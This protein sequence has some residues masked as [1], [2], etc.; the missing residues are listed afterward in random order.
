M[1]SRFTN[2]LTIGPDYSEKEIKEIQLYKTVASLVE[3]DPIFVHFEVGASIAANGNVGLIGTQITYFI[4]DINKLNQTI[5]NKYVWEVSLLDVSI[6]S[7]PKTIVDN[8]PVP[9]QPLFIK[10]DN[11]TSEPYDFVCTQPIEK[12]NNRVIYLNQ[13]T[14]PSQ[15]LIKFG[16][17]IAD[18]KS[19]GFGTFYDFNTNIRPTGSGIVAPYNL[20][21]N[22]SASI[23][24][25]RVSIRQ[26]HT[27]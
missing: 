15:L 4:R 18:Q 20:F 11:L 24:R 1:A 3:L 21:Y 8:V 26:I 27:A 23:I 5:F 25:F 9:L 6:T 7:Y 22:Q 10:L 19:A 17:C 14:F 12:Q 13:K 2:N 16:H